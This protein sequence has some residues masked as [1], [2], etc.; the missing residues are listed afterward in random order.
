V[1]PAI[2]PARPEDARFLAWVALA[3]ARSHLER[4]FWDLLIPQSESDR[5][6]YLEQLFVAEPPSWWHWS[7]FLVVE[8]D[9]RPQAALSGFDPADARFARPDEAVVAALAARGWSDARTQAGLARASPFFRCVHQ[10][11]PGSWM[12][13]SVATR[14]EARGS[15][16]AQALIE[17]V[18]EAG[19][20][21][22]HRA[23]QLNL[24]IGNTPAQRLYERFGF[25]VVA[26][27]RH[28]EF[29]AALGCPGIAR[30][31]CAL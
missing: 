9:G 2:R 7:I 13:E 17:R 14:P 29:E 3:S 24:L 12:V 28:P 6:D 21:G 26:E 15:G 23:A 22:G 4:G 10:P 20:A 31:T 8:R 19:R 11:E 30:M 1:A 5:L 27:R 25:R 18:L 16:L